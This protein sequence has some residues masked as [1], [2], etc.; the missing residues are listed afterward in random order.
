MNK[1]IPRVLQPG[2]VWYCFVL[3]AFTAAA[4]LLDQYY[5]AGAELVVTI[6]VFIISRVRFIR[7]KHILMDYVQSATDAVGISVHAGTPFPMAVIRLPD[8]EIIWGNP[9]FYSITGLSDATRYQTMDRV[10]PGFSTTWLREG[11]S[12]LPSDQT[13]NGR[14]YRVYGNY[15]RSEDDATTVMLATIF[16]ADMT[17]MFN[18]RDEFMRTRPIISVIL[19]DNYDELTNNL[20]DSAVSQIDAKINDAISAWPEGLHA[21]CRKIERNRYLLVFESKDLQKLQDGKFSLLDSIRSV[22]NSSGIAATVSLGVGK[23]GATFEENYSFAMLSIE[24]ALSRGGDQ[25]VIKDRYNFTFYGG[26]T[27]ETERHT[28]VKSRVVAGSLSELIA[29]SSQVFIMGHR[30]ADLDAL[31]AAAGIRCLCRKRGKPAHIVIDL[32]NNM[33][34]SLIAE[35]RQNEDYEDVFISG[36][37]ALVEADPRS[38]LIVVDTNRPAQVVL[39]L[40]EPFASSASEL[41]A[42]LLQY[43]VDQKDITPLEAQ[44]LLAGIVLDTKNFTVRTGSRTFEA[45]AFLRR[46]GADTVEVKK[47]FQ[48]DLDATILKYQVI[49]AARLYRNEIAISAV[50][51][52][53]PRAIASQASDELLN[54]SGILASFVLYPG[55]EGEVMISARSIGSCNVQMVLEPLGGG[56]NAATAGAQIRGSTVRDVLRELVASIDKFYET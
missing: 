7:R 22:Q 30:M 10:I 38:L 21:I 23:D 32:K 45:A 47:L 39:T 1:H 42:E 49:Q 25:A 40:H 51:T 29:Q 56:G 46:A 28:R 5:L 3:L 34:G 55:A 24:M 50:D 19:V 52:P 26:R 14:R 4:A 41:V 17:E 20:S 33:A 15:V 11:R 12:E 2:S 18:I 44:A 31:G 8:N 43:A 48:A 27:K 54:I 13:I 16:F 36:Q 9:G 35:L 37:D 6:A 53:V